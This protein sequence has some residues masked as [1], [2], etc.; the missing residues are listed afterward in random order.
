MIRW[1]SIT[2]LHF[3]F[4][5]ISFLRNPMAAF[6][7]TFFPLMFLAINSLVFGDFSAPDGGG[8]PMTAFYTAGM[9]VFAV[10]M[11]CFT[12]LAAG[13]LYDRDMGR[14]KRIRGTPT[15]ISSYI[16]AR[17]LLAMS[18]GV[19]TSIL[20][21]ILGVTAF[22]VPLD[23]SILP[24]FLGIILLGA[25][26]LSALGLAITGFIPNAQAGPAI[27]NAVSFPIIFGSNVFFP[28]PNMPRWL[29]LA[30]NALP[31]RPFADAATATFFG[32]RAD[33]H[34]LIIIAV[35]G[36]IG[37]IIAYR[38]FRWQPSR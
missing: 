24:G 20:C 7:G 35:W 16:A 28:I 10:V 37:G 2:L 19:V 29:D 12:N 34:D 38:S 30:A 4:A 26:S 8:L 33:L 9:S 17:I 23:L 1:L 31:V 21:V 18:V 15:P 22:G 36:C 25:A 11:T 27:L 5:A 6:F 13:L 3:R 14:L 32:G